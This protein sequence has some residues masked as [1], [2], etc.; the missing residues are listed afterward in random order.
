[1][2]SSMSGAQGDPVPLG[3]LG[4][5]LGGVGGRGRLGRQRD[6]TD[7]ER[8][9]SSSG[10]GAGDGSCGPL[11][12]RHGSRLASGGPGRPAR[13]SLDWRRQAGSPGAGPAV[14]R[15]RSLED[16]PDV[17]E[18]RTF[19]RG[20]AS[21]HPLERQWSRRR[22]W[23]AGPGSRPAAGARVGAAG[24]GEAGRG[25]R[26]CSA[27][28]ARPARRWQ[29]SL[30]D[31]VADRPRRHPGQIG[32][33]LKAVRDLI[34]HVPIVTVLRLN[35]KT[36]ERQI[37]LRVRRDRSDRRSQAGRRSRHQAAR[38]C[39]RSRPGSAH[40][41][42]ARIRPGRPAARS[43]R[44]RRRESAARTSR[45]V[46]MERTPEVAFPIDQ[47]VG[48]PA[49]LVTV[50]SVRRELLADPDLRSCQPVPRPQ[51][52]L[53][54]R[55]SACRRHLRAAREAPIAAGRERRR[56]A[57]PGRRP[58]GGNRRDR[59]SRGASGPSGW[60]EVGNRL[61]GAELDAVLDAASSHPS[62]RDRRAAL[63]SIQGWDGDPVQPLRTRE[64]PGARP[65]AINRLIVS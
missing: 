3:A 14:S 9:A 45:V 56:T 46:E 32:Q 24:S 64:S 35:V 49:S 23:R 19:G 62:R 31:V 57:R 50:E 48:I 2:L 17:V 33:V 63:V 40:R 65:C 59:S 26:P 58:P 8:P 42:S 7:D 22:A 53:E 47:L 15:R 44:G 29:Q 55:S 36:R 52:I 41:G 25:D 11:R 16:R 51:R 38:R 39:Q 21:R 20:R 30:G 43:A 6:P 5:R 1:M 37:D 12:A 27:R 60:L 28:R 13:G 54:A 18:R 4:S 61:V 34:R 10:W